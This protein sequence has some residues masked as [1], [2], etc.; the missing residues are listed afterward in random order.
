MTAGSWR[1]SAT[2]VLMLAV[3]GGVGGVRADTDGPI[4]LVTPYP[5]TGAPD[6]YGVPRI[7][8]MVKLVQTLTVPAVSDALAQ[9]LAW[10]LGRTLEHTVQIERRTG[11]QGADALQSV[12]RAQ[13]DGRVLLFA[14]NREIASKDTGRALV[15]VAVVAQMPI[16]LVAPED[17]AVND[18]QKLIASAGTAPRR[19]DIGIGGEGSST[20]RAVDVFKKLTGIEA[21]GIGYNGSTPALN[22]LASRN[23]DFAFVP[24]TAAMPFFGGGR[25]R[26]VAV[27]SVQRHRALPS[28][29]TLAEAGI[30]GYV[31][32]GWFGVFAPSMT[33]SPQIS[34]LNRAINR[35]IAD[36]A[37][38]RTQTARG[39][40]AYTLSPEAFE[41][42]VARERGERAKLMAQVERR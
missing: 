12:A 24:L 16:V 28:T 10:N 26:A 20:Q 41:M 38:Q 2:I 22:A 40:N 36:D 4:A 30:N 23:V 8:K 21:A 39:L 29:P 25:L 19:F 5:P 3:C 9:E 42:L 15:P 35:V 33:P 32:E 7:T 11:R 34:Q 17:G 14:G 18:V 1:L 31:V 13:T 27:G 6:I 37:W